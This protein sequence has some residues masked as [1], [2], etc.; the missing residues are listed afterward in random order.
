MPA[1]APLNELRTANE[2]LYMLLTQ[3][4]DTT[5][6]GVTG[7]DAVVRLLS[8]IA[9]TA[10]LSSM[11]AAGLN[12]TAAGA[13]ELAKYRNTLEELR[14]ILPA[15]QTRLLADRARLETERSHYYAASAWASANRR[16]L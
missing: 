16:T 1:D 12:Q 3:L 7:T 15:I 11:F 6:A 10:R 4:Q 13:A 5:I 9:S 14:R 8:Q 2:R